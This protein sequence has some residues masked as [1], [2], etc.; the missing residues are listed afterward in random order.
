MYIQK[1]IYE[2]MHKHTLP[3]N[4]PSN[5]LSK[6]I[7][8]NMNFNYRVSEKTSITTVI[9]LKLTTFPQQN[10]KNIHISKSKVVV[11]KTIDFMQFATKCKFD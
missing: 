7:K 10:K 1:K 4:K 5:S 6:L 2:I 8:R 3:H 9:M 11:Q